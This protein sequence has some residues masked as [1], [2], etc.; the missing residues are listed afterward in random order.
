MG[1]GAGDGGGEVAV[2]GRVGDG[3]AA[4]AV[5][6]S[7]LAVAAEALVAA[8]ST[9]GA[10]WPLRL[11]QPAKVKA[12][13]TSTTRE[14]AIGSCALGRKRIGSGALFNVLPCHWRIAPPGYLCRSPTGGSCSVLVVHQTHAAKSKAFAAAAMASYSL[15]VSNVC[16]FGPL[17]WQKCVNLPAKS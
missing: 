15:F 4:R 7:M 2:G 16:L 10:G 1:S 12:N 6:A 14:F 8:R 11:R 9:A 13:K 5:D 3:V 17:L